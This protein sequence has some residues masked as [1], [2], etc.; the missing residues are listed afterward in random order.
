M[1]QKPKPSSADIIVD[2]HE[3]AQL[4]EESSIASSRFSNGDI[5]TKIV[6]N[7]IKNKKWGWQFVAIGCLK[8]IYFLLYISVVVML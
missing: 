4:Q 7:T 8:L 2:G 1:R 3:E 5:S 6:S